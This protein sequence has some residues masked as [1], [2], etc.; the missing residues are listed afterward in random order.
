[1]NSQAS[2]RYWV[3]NLVST[4]KMEFDFIPNSPR[5]VH[6]TFSISRLPISKSYEDWNKQEPGIWM[7]QRYA[8]A[9]C[10]QKVEYNM[11]KYNRTNIFLCFCIQNFFMN[12]TDF[13]FLFSIRKLQTLYFN[14]VVIKI[15]VILIHILGKCKESKAHTQ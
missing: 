5:K 13:I 3:A 8:N 10:R 4:N 9:R 11:T 14:S 7:Q 2:T 6:K 1:M 15:Q 12:V